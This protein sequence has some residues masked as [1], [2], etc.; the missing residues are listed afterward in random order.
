[1]VR[2]KPKPPKKPSVVA[3]PPLAP[4]TPSPTTRFERDVERMRKRGADMERFR[5][6]IEALCSRQP[7]P[8]ELRDHALSGEWKGCRDCHVSPDWIVIYERAESNLILYRTGTDAD[9]FES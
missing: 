1:M 2:R 9:L 6:I 8:A 4:L 3:P 5:A 7:L